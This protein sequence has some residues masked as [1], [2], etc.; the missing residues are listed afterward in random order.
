MKE[1]SFKS[2]SDIDDV[3]ATTLRHG[4]Y[5]SR[6]VQRE[7]GLILRSVSRGE[8]PRL[9]SDEEATLDLERAQTDEDQRQG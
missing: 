4:L 9:L 1:V 7:I 5:E 8:P 6:G 2:Y 3:E